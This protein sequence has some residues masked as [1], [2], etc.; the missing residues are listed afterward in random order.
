MT[1]FQ[2]TDA[3]CTGQHEAEY[4]VSLPPKMQTALNE[5]FMT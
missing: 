4:G 1:E 2:C 3:P 5:V